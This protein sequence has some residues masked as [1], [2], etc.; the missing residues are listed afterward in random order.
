MNH[1]HSPEAWTCIINQMNTF[2]VLFIVHHVGKDIPLGLLGVDTYGLHNINIGLW[3]TF[4][5]FSSFQPHSCLL[6][7]SK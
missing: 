3:A 4:I 7:N 1:P 2:T 6:I 5:A